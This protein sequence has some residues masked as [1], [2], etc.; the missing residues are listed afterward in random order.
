MTKKWMEGET[1]FEIARATLFSV[2]PQMYSA[3]AI[4]D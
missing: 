1:F 2:Q 3:I 4:F